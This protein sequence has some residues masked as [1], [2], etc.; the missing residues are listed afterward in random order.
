L[1]HARGVVVVNS[2]VGLSA[3]YHN[4]PLKACG[5][6]IYDMPGLTFAGRLEEFWERAQS[7]NV[8]RELFRRFRS[9]LIEHTQLNGSFYKRL[10]LPGSH[11]GLVWSKVPVLPSA[12]EA[13][14]SATL[15]MANQ[16]ASA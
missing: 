10:N 1:H 11:T 3:L 6:A 16:G 15:P 4:A 14:G 13:I 2:T 12:G 9:Y 7:I 8:D 5:A